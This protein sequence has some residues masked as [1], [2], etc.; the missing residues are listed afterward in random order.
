MHEVGETSGGHRYLVH[1]FYGGGSLKERL[2]SGS[3]DTSEALRLTRQL[4][5]GLGAAHQRE[6]VH[7]DIKPANL[8][9]DAHGT[10]KICDF[11]IAKL[12]GGT[13]LT[14]TGV[15]LG[16]PA[17]KSPEQAQGHAVDHRTDL[18]AA[19]V[20]FYELLTGRRPFD[21]EFEQAVVR[22]I[23]TRTPR[24]LED[25]QGRPLP[26]A[27]RAFIEK[28]LDKDPT[29]RFQNAEEMSLALEAA[30][31]GEAR[32]ET[33]RRK[34]WIVL[35]AGILAALLGSM[36][37]STDFLPSNLLS[38][39][40]FFSKPRHET[41]SKEKRRLLSEGKDVEL[42]LPTDH[43]KELED[44]SGTSIPR[45]TVTPS[46]LDPAG[47]P[48]FL[49]FRARKDW[50]AGNHLE[51]LAEV[52]RN[53]ERAV[54]T[55]PSS[56]DAA[57]HLA[58]F[59]AERY[60]FDKNREKRQRALELAETALRTDSS[61]SLAFT[62]KARVEIT[63][64]NLDLA[65]QLAARAIERKPTCERDELCD[66][67]YR[68][69]A[70]LHWLQGRF[71]D[72]FGVLDVCERTGGGYIRCALKKAQIHEHQG[73][74]DEAKRQYLR[75]L[76]LAANQTTALSDYAL[77]LLENEQERESI[78]IYNQLLKFTADPT[79]FNNK[80][81]ALYA[82]RRWSDAMAAFRTA[83]EG[84]TQQGRK[85]PTPLVNM[86]DIELEKRDPDEARGYYRAALEVFESIENPRVIRQGQKLVCLAKL[87]RF[88]EANVG[89]A[90]IL[91]QA[92]QFPQ[93]LKYRAIILALQGKRAELFEA[94]ARGRQAG[95][96]PADFLDDP[97]FL[98]YREDEEYLRVVEPEA[99]LFIV[100]R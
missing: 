71:A 50:L 3:I 64:G 43:T 40:D 30:E 19:G 93:L 35:A 25:A 10:L 32:F 97:G 9:L 80:G 52:L 57:G 13:D 61:S 76:N 95:L 79:A 99:S 94:V 70:D 28:A 49:L 41:L 47:D 2:A 15:P 89:M 53:F 17:Y 39:P 68:C 11:G 54:R 7:R 18:W 66:L 34:R 55:D 6:I 67:A 16:T 33:P 46:E 1:A 90:R 69:L 24:A 56:A 29:Q 51:N 31:R 96:L 5:A 77:L 37:W 60:F 8:L 83:H 74:L 91:D 14:H 59:L 85:V 36:L 62:A 21:G 4:V 58:V 63:D 38:I 82:R 12:L 92:A 42:S 23:L 73:N 75:V 44:T 81:I 98:E 84:F 88:E 86:G 22:S 45:S 87:G 20:V 27:V 48:E 72:A 100:P 78:G 65:E 26:E